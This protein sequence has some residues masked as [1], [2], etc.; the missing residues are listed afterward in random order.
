MTDSKNNYNQ[1]QKP[2]G[3]GFTFFGETPQTPELEEK[4]LNN[5]SFVNTG[6]SFPLAIASVGER[7]AIAKLKGT[8][9][10]V[11]RLIGM[12]LVPGSELQVISIANGSVI[13]ALGDNRIGLGVGMAQ[14]ILCTNLGTSN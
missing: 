14:K 7:L 2:K 1:H 4:T 9:G 13:I 6:K 12:G 8:E 3:W 5:G 11:R 10:T